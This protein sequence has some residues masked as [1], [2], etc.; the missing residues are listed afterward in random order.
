[1]SFYL[2][3]KPPKGLSNL[4]GFLRTSAQFAVIATRLALGFAGGQS[5]F[6]TESRS[7]FVRISG[8][9]CLSF[10]FMRGDN[11]SVQNP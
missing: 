9:G 1:M 5:A 8:G 3:K 6:T 7:G 11:K 4:L 2:N 10:G